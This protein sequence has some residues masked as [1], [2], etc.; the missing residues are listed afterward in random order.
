MAA[1]GPVNESYNHLW[2]LFE[3]EYKWAQGIE[4]QVI[5]SNKEFKLIELEFKIKKRM[6]LLD[7]PIQQYIA[8]TLVANQFLHF[9]HRCGEAITIR[10]NKKRSNPRFCKF[11]YLQPDVE[12]VCRWTKEQRLMHLNKVNV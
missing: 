11:E 3:F 9:C 1:K 2:E 10:P 6:T 12:H 8:S 5:F 4:E 7:Q